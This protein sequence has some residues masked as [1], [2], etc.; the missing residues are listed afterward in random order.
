MMALSMLEQ[1]QFRNVL[2]PDASDR[3]LAR[4]RALKSSGYRFRQVWNRPLGTFQGDAVFPNKANRINN[5][6]NNL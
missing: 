2:V 1:V 4:S 5:H 3:L 6:A